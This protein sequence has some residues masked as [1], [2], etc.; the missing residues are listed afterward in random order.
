MEDGCDEVVKQQNIENKTLMCQICFAPCDQ[1]NVDSFDSSGNVIH[2]CS[3]CSPDLEEASVTNFVATNRHQCEKCPQNFSNTENLQAHFNRDHV[4]LRFQCNQCPC[5][6][7]RNGDLKNHIEFKHPEDGVHIAKII[8][9]CDQCPKSCVTMFDLR[10]HIDHKHNGIWQQCPQCPKKYGKAG[11]LKEHIKSA[12]ELR[13]FVCDLCAKKFG[14]ATTLRRHLTDVHEQLTPHVCGT[15]QQQ[16]AQLRNCQMHINTVHKGLKTFHCET[17]DQWFAWKGN[18]KTHRMWM[19]TPRDSV[20]FVEWHE[21]REELERKR[22][23]NNPDYKFLQL[24][25]SR[26][27]RFFGDMGITKCGAS[28]EMMGGD[29]AEATKHLHNN[30]R[31]LVLGQKDPPCHVDHIRPLASFKH[32]DCHK[33]QMEACHYLNLQLLPTTENLQKKAK[34]NEMKY[35]LSDSWREL[36]TL[37]AIWEVEVVCP[38][39]RCVATAGVERVYRAASE[40]RPCASKGKIRDGSVTY[41]TSGSK[42][43]VVEQSFTPCL[44]VSRKRVKVAALWVDI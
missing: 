7:T 31:G 18:L 24:C 32:M 19:H 17:C 10:E 16:F 36:S 44:W 25:R 9:Q 20:E 43:A 39:E 6:Y 29:L 3:A 5:K 28:I 21:N 40:M 33:V 37:V 30:T 11:H 34:Y 8:Y 15:C 2:L 4:G 27:G 1:Q 26:M 22:Y 35:I 42:P 41:V 14:S 23:E 13:R 38:C 12:H